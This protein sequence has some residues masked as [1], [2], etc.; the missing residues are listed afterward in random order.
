[1]NNLKNTLN[2]DLNVENTSKQLINTFMNIDLTNFKIEFMNSLQYAILSIIPIIL[3]LKLI[4]NIIPNVDETKGT[5]EILFESV[6]QI[7]LT[8]FLILSINYLVRLIPTYSGESYTKI[9]ILNYIVPFLFLMLTMQTKIG[10]KIN[11]LSNR[12]LDYWNG[13]ADNT[14]K[15]NTNINSV[16]LRNNLTNIPVVQ[17][18]IQHNK[19]PPTIP[20]QQFNSSNS[21]NTNYS[22]SKPDFNEMY[23]NNNSNSNNSNSEYMNMNATNSLVQNEPIAAN[24]G[25]NSVYSNW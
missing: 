7:S 15:K 1:M 10:E 13:N 5:M 22:V 3:T 4:K 6:G 16:N 12:F 8:I 21:D 24:L 14:N 2:S 25:V 20:T 17:D 18:N 23:Q 19:L 9:D 11:I